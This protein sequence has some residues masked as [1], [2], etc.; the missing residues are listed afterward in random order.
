MWMRFVEM[1]GGKNFIKD[2]FLLDDNNELEA[3]SQFCSLHLCQEAM[4]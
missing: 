3:D 1:K 4:T 2:V